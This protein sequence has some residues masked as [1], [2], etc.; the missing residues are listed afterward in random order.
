MSRGTV[1]ALVNQK[2]GTGKTQSTENIGI[3]LAKEGKRVLLVD[4]DPQGSLTISMGYPKTDD[5]P[6]TVTD[7]MSGVLQEY[8]IGRAHV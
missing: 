3:G 7:I 8:Q 6:V 1:Y 2:G 5:I 4:L